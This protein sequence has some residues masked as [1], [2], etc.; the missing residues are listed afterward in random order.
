MAQNWLSG[1]SVELALRASD[2]CGRG[3]ANEVGTMSDRAR[4]PS[5]WAEWAL[6]QAEHGMG[7]VRVRVRVRDGRV[8]HAI[9]IG[10][11][12]VSV[13]GQREILFAADE[14]VQLER[15]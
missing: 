13:E 8:T 6:D 3:R 12:V 4:L 10:V 7:Y 9:V 1:F 5:P 14:I 11:T 15:A 2:E